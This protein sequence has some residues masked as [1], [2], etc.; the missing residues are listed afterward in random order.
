MR[1]EDFIE[2]SATVRILEK[3]VLSD[4]GLGRIADAADMG[5][6]LRLLSQNSSFDIPGVQE[7]ESAIK[8]G[9][10]AAYDEMRKH[11]PDM[12]VVDAAALP[13]EF[14][15]IKTAVKTKHTG[16][17]VQIYSDI[18]ALAAGVVLDYVFG[19]LKPPAVGEDPVPDYVKEAVAETE[20][21]YAET[22][23]PQYI[24]IVLDKHMFARLFALC[25]GIGNE[26]IS[27]YARLV[28]DFHNLKTLLRVKNMQKGHRFLRDSLVAGGE[29]P[30][31][32]FVKHY[33]KT[34][35]ALAQAFHYKT[36]GDLVKQGVDIHT[37]AG[38][39]AG[40]EK[41]LDDH[42]IRHIQHSKLVAY[43]PDV[44]FAYLI[45]RENEARAARLIIACKLK[46]MGSDELRERLRDNY[47]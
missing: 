23:D 26:F 1:D 31:E 8:S 30:P 42:L 34:S 7:A 29:A 21:V 4:A 19:R 37:Q 13:Y 6:T 44:P 14:H 2:I 25:E 28:A 12:A 39:Y 11:I 27:G 46:G 16:K 32:F 20:A 40:L 45:S 15:N 10:K 18:P 24:D 35:D 33:D 43:G 17:D 9:L 38:N 36:F 22:N 5:E 47:A 41:I 3:S